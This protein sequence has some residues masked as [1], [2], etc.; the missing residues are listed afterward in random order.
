MIHPE[1]SK[2]I[3]NLSIGIIKY[4]NI[5]VEDSPQMLKGRLQLFQESLFFDLEDKNI[6]DINEIKDWRAIFKQLGKDPNR[7]RHSAE[8]LYRRVKKQDFLPSMNSAADINNF[9]HFNIVFLLEYMIHPLLKVMW[10][11]V[12]ARQ[13]KHM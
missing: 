1:L 11:Y 6:N 7:Y 13:T 12:K 2:A 3:S 10:N 4:D 5:I 8:S 9:F